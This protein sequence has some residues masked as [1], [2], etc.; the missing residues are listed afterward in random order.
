VRIC[1]KAIPDKI[2]GGN[3][4]GVC[5]LDEWLQDETPQYDT[6]KHTHYN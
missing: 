2:F 6:I 3:P 5:L 4:A 1:K